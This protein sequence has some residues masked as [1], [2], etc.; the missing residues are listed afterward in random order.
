LNTVCDVC[1][2]YFGDTLELALARDS[3]E[4]QSRFTHGVR[5]PEE[6]KPFGR[7]SRIVFRIAEGDFAGAYAYREYSPEAADILLRPLPQ[8]GFLM[9]TGAYVYFLLDEI[10]SEEELRVKG[11]D[12]LH[13]KA[14]CGL[15]IEK[16]E[17]L[18]RLAKKGIAFRVA[19]E[20]VPPQQ[21]DGVLC[22]VEGSI[23]E[24]IFRAVAKIAFNYL[25][26]WE[27]SEWTQG[28]SFD[29][30]RRFVRYG[31]QLGYR[32]VDV[33][34]AAILAD[35]PIVGRR[36]AGHL[37]T[38]NWA[39]DRM[40]IVSQIALFNWITYRVSL[41]VGYRGERRNIRRGHFFNIAT[42][43]I[44]ELGA[45]CRRVDGASE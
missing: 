14:I 40:S 13:P 21:A 7:N 11:F 29:A 4:G 1:N 41:A 27:G 2:Q 43:E 24:K 16:D 17:L 23:D 15:A 18:D 31:E 10:P 8:V 33:C 44:L 6:Y 22:E 45:R 3:F 42:S 26:Y 35:E 12:S 9:P 30:V 37:I 5:D 38:V 28:A 32:M 19:D 36:R 25:A 39:Q 20:V 34:D